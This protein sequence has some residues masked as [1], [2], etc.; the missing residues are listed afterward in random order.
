MQ[1]CIPLF[2]LVLNVS[3]PMAYCRYRKLCSKVV[4]ARPVHNQHQNRITAIMFSI[5]ILYLLLSLPSMLAIILQ[6][7]DQDYSPFG[8]YSYVHHFLMNLGSIL[9]QVN[10]ARNCLIY[11]SISKDLWLKFNV[12]CLKD[13]SM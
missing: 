11:V 9:T 13:S 3:I 6:F 12:T 1:I 10:A 4:T 8:R 5:I 7:Y 2:V